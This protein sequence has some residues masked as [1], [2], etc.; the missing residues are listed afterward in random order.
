VAEW[1]QEHLNRQNSAA[2]IRQR[3]SDIPA[4]L[5]N[6]LQSSQ[7]FETL[8][9]AVLEAFGQKGEPKS[10][11][12]KLSADVDQPESFGEYDDTIRQAVLGLA[13]VAAL[14]HAP[15]PEMWEYLWSLAWHSAPLEQFLPEAIIAA[16]AEVEF[17]EEFFANRAERRPTRRSASG[18][19]CD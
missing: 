18:T 10:A 3:L 14:R 19:S 8:V 12:A 13:G 4:P 1:P 15:T 9:A 7:A 2:F 11:I 6:Q 17:R 5:I 16:A